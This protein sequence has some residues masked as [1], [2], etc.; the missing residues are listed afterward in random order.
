VNLLQ[1]TADYLRE[2]QSPV[3]R[4]FHIIILCLVLSQLFVS[5]F[6]GF[7]DNG[8]ISRKTGEFYGTW[9][10]IITG[11]TLVPIV[12]LFIIIEL[13]RRGFKYF[14]PY[15]YGN[16]AQIKQD[17]QSLQR[18]QLPEPNPYGIATIVQGLGFGALALVVLSGMTWFFSWEYGASWS[19]G[20]KEVHELFTG[21]IVAYVIGHGGMGVL[22][23]FLQWKNQ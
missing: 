13:K 10:H 18:I 19:D 3:V 1:T 21:L 17:L 5:N 23:I 12:L 8:E 16:F 22:H 14:F 6:M 9:I 20:I 4:Y 2:R 15:F 11:L 7:A